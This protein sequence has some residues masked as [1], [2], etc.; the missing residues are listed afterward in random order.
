MIGRSED[1]ADKSKPRAVLRG[2]CFYNSVAA[3]KTEL[4][5][6]KSL[7]R[8]EFC[9]APKDGKEGDFGGEEI[10]VC[11]EKYLKRRAKKVA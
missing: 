10:F 2:A 3:E 8:G 9:F 11:L 4:T 6:G 5:A 1:I 7:K